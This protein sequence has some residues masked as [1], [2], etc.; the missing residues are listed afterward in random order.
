MHPSGTALVTGA[1]RGIG[2]AT[3]LELSRR[4]FDVVASMRDP[5]DG[6]GLEAQARDEGHPLRIARLD[7]TRP[8]TIRIPAGLRVLVNNAGVET[9]NRSVEYTPMEHWRQVFE[10][11]L[12]GL[13]EVTRRA[14]D[15]LRAAGGGVVCN[16]T[17]CSTLVPMPFFGAYRA[18]KAAVST[19]GESLRVE[20]APFGIRVVEIMPGAIETDMLAASPLLPAGAT[21]P[22]YAELGEQV[23]VSRELA[24]GISTPVADAA[25]AI[26]DAILDD[27]GPLRH[28]CDPMGAGL[29]E[30]WRANTDEQT[31][32]PMRAL[33]APRS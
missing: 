31:M 11:N 10:T 18:S 21:D 9:E 2:R 13:V 4:G 16:V 24:A 8:D 20:L 15:S 7:V 29:L 12:F 23:R 32:E 25:A 27:D 3:A 22:G 14:V 1:S 6:R 17:S 26:A 5:A 33:F 19:L 30:S 28:A